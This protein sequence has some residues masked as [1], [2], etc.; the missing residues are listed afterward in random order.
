MA[1]KVL[2]TAAVSR[3]KLP[4]SGQLDVYD[5]GYP[6][7]FLRLS[8]GGTRSFNMAYRF[9]GK[10]RRV[11]LGTFP[12]MSL[13]EARDAWRQIRKSINEN[14]DPST[15]NSDAES[16]GKIAADWLKRDQV[17]NRSHD[18]VKRLVAVDVLPRWKDRPINEIKRRDIIEL[19]DAVVDRGS[20]IMAR[21]LHSHLHRLFQWSVGRGI[22]VANPMVGLPKPGSEEKPRDRVLS[23]LELKRVW[24]AASRM[25]WPFGAIYRLL[26]LTGARLREIGDLRWS[27]IHGAHIRLEGSRTK[28]G[29]AHTIPLSDPARALLNSVPRIGINSD[30]VFS[31]NGKTSVSGWSKAKRQLLDKTGDLPDFHV[32]DFRRV[33]AT[34]M[35]RLGIAERVIEA[36]LGHCT[37]SRNGLLR[38]YQVHGFD[39]EKA[40]A[41][42]LWAHH[43]M[44]LVGHKLRA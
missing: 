30:L 40:E 13:A 8:Y 11:T 29:T 6:G 27:E 43:V 26:I 34:G 3:M 4:A 2:T 42:A 23:D 35:Q 5:R 16:F 44:A 41:L 7:L 32:H 38:V 31:T 12:A 19:I 22:I 24:D 9:A 17:N 39:R 1:K 33:V 15:L 20:P 25:D 10:Q 14:L 37:T 21:R 36:C 18:A 28:S